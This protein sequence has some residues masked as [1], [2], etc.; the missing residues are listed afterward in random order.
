MNSNRS[1]YAKGII[2]LVLGILSIIFIDGFSLMLSILAIFLGEQAQGTAGGKM[3]RIGKNIAI[4]SLVLNALVLLTVI[5]VS[6]FC[7]SYFVLSIM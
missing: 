1:T 2:S 5:V 7:L 4:A 3:G 6:F